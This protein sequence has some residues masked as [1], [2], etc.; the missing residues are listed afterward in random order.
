[1]NKINIAIDGPAAAG[2]STIAKRVA[3]ALSMIYVDTGAMYRAIT[4]AHLEQPE[5]EIDKLVDHIDLKLVNRSGQRIYLNGS[6]V[7][8]RI[9]EHDVTLNVSRI[10]S[11]ES[12]RTK[13]VNLQQN[14][15]ANKGVVMDGRDIGT[16]VIP[17]AELKVYMVASVEERAERRLIDN[18]NRGIASTFEELK[19]DIERRDHLD[20]TR[21]I[22]PLTKAEDAI[23]IDTTGKSIEEV[24][25]QI[26]EL[27]KSAM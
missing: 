3:E 19:R 10:A 23:E 13:L 26:I 12:V 11:I 21:E 4:L 22:S 8:D 20:M 1:M 2:K 5:T 6:D 15:T 24:T 16:K 17:E 27:A 9:R 18:R 7:S 25:A 14:M